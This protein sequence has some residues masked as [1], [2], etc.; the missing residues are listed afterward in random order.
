MTKP[1][2][3]RGQR[4]RAAIE[5]KGLSQADV[6]REVGI[7]APHLW[8]ILEDKANPSLPTLE[9]IAKALGVEPGELI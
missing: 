6:A 5:A 1:K 3:T 9:R 4:M 8:Q 2:Q 7:S